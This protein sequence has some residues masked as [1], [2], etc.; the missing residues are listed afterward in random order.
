MSAKTTPREVMAAA[1]VRM[2]CSGSKP[3]QSHALCGHSMLG[4]VFAFSVGVGSNILHLAST[5]ALAVK[6]FFSFAGMAL[7]AVRLRRKFITASSRSSSCAQVAATTAPSP[8]G[9]GW[10]GGE[11]EGMDFL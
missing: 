10:D 8:R 4:V 7:L 2:G 5:A 9:D 11:G 3:A 6:L 1:P